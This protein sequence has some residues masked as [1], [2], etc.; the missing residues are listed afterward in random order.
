MLYYVGMV[1]AGLGAG[2][3]LGALTY[4][5][6]MLGCVIGAMFALVGGPV[7]DKVLTKD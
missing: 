2:V 3:L 6:I 1:F 5:S 7:L 4:V